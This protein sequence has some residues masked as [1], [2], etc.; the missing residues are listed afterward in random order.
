MT[1]P[2][3]HELLADY[4]RTGSETAFARLVARHINLV[5]S[6]A[7]RYTGSDPHAEE[8]TQ[9]VFLILARKA[10]SISKNIVISGWL[11]QTARLTAANLLKAERRRQLR[12]QEAFMQSQ[13]NETDAAVWREI[14]P[15]LDDAMGRLSAADRTVLVLRFFERQTNA[16]VAAA[17]GLAEAAV[18]KRVLRA[19]EKL[20][21]N[22]A[23]QGVTHAAQAIAGIVTENAVL[24]APAGLAAIIAANTAKGA[25]V[26][27]S[28]TALANGTIKT[29]TMT[30]IQ[31]I[32]VTAALTVS[33]G[34][35]I[36]QAKETAKARAEVQTLQQQQAPLA[37]QIQQLQ[38]EHDEATKR[39]AWLNEEL[40]KN[41]KNILELLK[42]RGEVGVLRQQL[43][44]TKQGNA[45]PHSNESAV[46]SQPPERGK[47]PMSA[48]E[49]QNACIN[50][51]R[52]IDAAMQQC[53]LQHKLSATNIVTAEQVLPF[54]MSQQLPQCPAGGSYTFGSLSDVPTCSISGHALPASIGAP[55]IEM[56][57][58]SIISAI[59]RDRMIPFSSD[60]LAE[61]REAYKQDH[62]GEKSGSMNE[63]I[64]YLKQPGPKFQAALDTYKQSH[65]SLM[66]T[67]VIELAPFFQ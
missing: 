36:Y 8:I 14:A 57:A 31:K 34:V 29:I 66:P 9:A 23:K 40:A 17:L 28:V 11:Y 18:Q 2:T 32:A 43:S 60:D 35:G 10:G 37:E 53:A 1:E 50:Y 52:Q 25:T 39:I 6:T 4:A 16:Q 59:R 46:Q 22:F 67:N 5:H 33:V 64:L 42:L 20:R 45:V 13:E 44:Q 21:A 27:A 55:A 38:T 49:Q 3:D 30:T 15:L 56:L 51:L 63:F 41:E 26:A 12:E 24:I 7:R 62:S 65:N 48:I 58:G 19:L 61:A 54:L 47:S